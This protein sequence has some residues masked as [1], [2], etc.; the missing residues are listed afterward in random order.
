MTVGRAFQYGGNQHPIEAGA[1]AAKV[2][3]RSGQK[4]FV[5]GDIWFSTK[6]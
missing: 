3:L 5:K 1:E 4:P 2:A 6:A